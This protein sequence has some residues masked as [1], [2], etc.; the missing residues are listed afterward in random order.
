MAGL[1]HNLPAMTN[2]SQYRR[3]PGRSGLFVRDSLWISAGHLLSVRRNPFSESYR[4]FYFSDIQAIVI[5][6]LP[7]LLS[8][9]GYAAAGFLI[10]TAIAL[11][12][13]RHPAWGSLCTIGALAAFIVSR[14]SANCACY[15]Q[16]SV[17]T[18]LLPSLRKRVD[19]GKAEALLKAEVEKVQGSVSAE[20]LEAG[21]VDSRARRLAKPKPELRHCSG[22][23]HWI[24]FAL[25][26]VWGALTSVSMKV[27]SFPFG[28]AAGVV[29]TV[30]LL[31]LILAAIQQR[32]SD[33]A[34]N[35][36]RAVYVGLAFYLASGLVS[37]VV[38]INIAWRLGTGVKGSAT[39]MNDPAFKAFQLVDLIAFCLV[40]CVGLILMWRH[41]R[42]LRTPP[43]LAVG[44][45]G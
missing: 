41:T 43:P 20:V 19:A 23:V 37:F 2:K 39:I 15:L 1:I 36:R 14:R 35:V 16:T 27:V 8:P 38:S 12:Y 17:S 9:Y 31:L 33:L 13:T 28:I 32:N 40:G 5:T 42:T 30:V 11:V 44:N 26:L 21:S 45:G 29:S 25:I 24:A 18:E 4:R 10:V 7:D 3:V 6:E 34:L 22:Q